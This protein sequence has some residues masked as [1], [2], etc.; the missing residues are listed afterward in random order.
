[1]K[2]MAEELALARSHLSDRLTA[3]LRN[4]RPAFPRP[5]TKSC[6]LEFVR[7]SMELTYGYRRVCA[8]INH[9]LVSMGSAMAD[10]QARVPGQRLQA[11]FEPDTRQQH[12]R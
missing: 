2:R 5:R 11:C 6:C 12:E 7:S 4:S 3:G 9:Q 1:M 8:L 10:P